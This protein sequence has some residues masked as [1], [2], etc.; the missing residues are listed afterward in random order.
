MKSQQGMALVAALLFL[1]LLTSAAVVSVN[2]MTLS[3]RMVANAELKTLTFN[4]AQQ[5]LIATSELDDSQ[6]HI[7]TCNGMDESDPYN[8]AIPPPALSDAQKAVFPCTVTTETTTASF[9][10]EGK[11]VHRK[12]TASGYNREIADY[13]RLRANQV[14]A[15]IT[16]TLIS[17]QYKLL[18]QANNTGDFR[19]TSDDRVQ[20]TVNSDSN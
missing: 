8:P 14:K 2:Q 17:D 3:P 4:A 19:R 7:N 6:F 9:L 16:S 10:A 11:P 5:E 15:G 18:I 12:E 1:L 13:Y 20:V